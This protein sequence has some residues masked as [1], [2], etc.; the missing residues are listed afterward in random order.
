[1]NPEDAAALGVGDGDEIRIVSASG[2][3]RIPARLTDEVMRGVLAVPHGWGHQGGWQVANA[4]GGVNVNVLASNRAEDLE[5]LAG[6]AFLNG[7]PVRV[8]AVVPATG[9]PVVTAAPVG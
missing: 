2:E 6:M 4:A 5:P 8:E 3:V 9:A 1:M 7:I